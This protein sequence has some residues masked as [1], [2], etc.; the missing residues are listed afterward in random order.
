MTTDYATFK[1]LTFS[2]GVPATLNILKGCE[3]DFLGDFIEVPTFTSF[4]NTT[5]CFDE[6][7]R[8][9]RDQEQK[10]RNCSAKMGSESVRWISGEGDF[11]AKDDTGA[12]L[13]LNDNKY[14][15]CLNTQAGKVS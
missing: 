4:Q 1:F 3:T 7:E 15:A 11:S 13:L 2:S 8:D 14:L 5:T 12:I 10:V 6:R 9:Q